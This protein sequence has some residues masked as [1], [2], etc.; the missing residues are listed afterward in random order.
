[1]F[2]PFDPQAAAA[3]EGGL[4]SSG[5]RRASWEENE[6]G[7]SD[8]GRPHTP[9]AAPHAAPHA[10]APPPQ[11]QPPAPD[12]PAPPACVLAGPPLGWHE[13][14]SVSSVLVAH[15]VNLRRATRKLDPEDEL[16]AYH[17]V[18]AALD[19]VLSPDR[20]T[21]WKVARYELPYYCA[22]CPASSTHEHADSLVR[23]ALRLLAAA[24]SVELPNG[25]RA[26]VQLGVC[27]G[28]SS[29]GII[30]SECMSFI[31]TGPAARAARQ[32]ADT[33]APL[34]V[35][36]STWERLGPDMR[37]MRGWA[38]APP[39]PAAAP[40]PGAADAYSLL[41]DGFDAAA[42]RAAG[43]LSS[44]DGGA[45]PAG[46]P[47][48]AGPGAC[49]GSCSGQWTVGRGFLQ[50]RREA[51]F[52]SWH[53]GALA[54]F[55][56]M[57]LLASLASTALVLSRRPAHA[58]PPSVPCRPQ[59]ALLEA[60]ALLGPGALLLLLRLGGGAIWAKRRERI[61][62][63]AKAAALLLRTAASVLL[64]AAPAAAAAAAASRGGLP[65]PAPAS[66][67]AAQ[68]AWLLGAA[69]SALACKV[70]L[71]SQLLLSCAALALAGAAAAHDAL[72]S[73]PPSAGDACC[74]L[75]CAVGAEA[76]H[77][78][79]VYAWDAHLRAAFLAGGG[80][81]GGGGDSHGRGGHGSSNGGV[82]PCGP[83]AAK[84]KAV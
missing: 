28:A 41:P 12:A 40:G 75:L 20:E 23:V 70:R 10:P 17:R 26:V 55:D 16:L 48:G 52:L 43:A 63:A 9:T 69:F 1:M 14:Y 72:L 64:G 51:E 3:G 32:L 77:C 71:Q 59:L 42:W 30:G 81:G 67:A 78:A 2:R 15:V 39:A 83:N 61:C 22:M 29:A 44:D 46:E 45:P 73:A 80:G 58:C 33:A 57:M 79:A 68:A 50:R 18:T 35:S 27:T 31:V 37:G 38:E 5:G 24:N 82:A 66:G 65:L 34:T 7:A 84:A 19:R 47:A 13:S 8:D 11:P 21:I 49:D 53:D 4:L 54:A 60:L 6:H 62:V 25:E 36:G 76:L 74:A 56:L